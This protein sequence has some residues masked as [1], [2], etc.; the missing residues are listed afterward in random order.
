MRLID[1]VIERA[2]LVFER[3]Y[4]LVRP[5]AHSV[6][7]KAVVITGLIVMVG[8]F[9]EPY[10]RA[11]LESYLERTVD[12]P[13]APFWGFLLVLSGLI[14]HLLAV[15]ADSLRRVILASRNRDHDGPI[16]RDFQVKVPE[17]KLLSTLSQIE[18]DHSIW[19]DNTILDDA[20]SVLRSPG[21]HLIDPIVREK[22]AK[23]DES[24]AALSSFIAYE[25]FV[26]SSTTGG[27]LRLCLRPDWNVDRSGSRLPTPEDD[28]RYD[29]LAKRLEALISAVARA[30]EDFIRTAHQ[31]V[32]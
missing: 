26:P 10:L 21:A 5:A 23:L 14:Y 7:G 27:R 29:D 2:L 6:I 28:A 25:F 18:N 9:W 11:F 20:C 32:L 17:A 15:R 31:L 3:V 30:Y 22:A 8:P 12:P 19:A 4:P 1:Y 16:V 13:T 24:I